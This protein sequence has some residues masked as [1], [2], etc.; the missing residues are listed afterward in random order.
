MVGSLGFL[1]WKAAKGELTVSDSTPSTRLDSG[2]RLRSPPKITQK[3]STWNTYIFYCTSPENQDAFLCQSRLP[4]FMEKPFRYVQNLSLPSGVVKCLWK[5]VWEIE[6]NNGIFLITFGGAR[7]IL[8]RLFGGGWKGLSAKYSP[9]LA[10]FP[11]PNIRVVFLPV[12]FPL[13]SSSE[14]S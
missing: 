5:V 9:C 12:S 8:L 1:A 10:E 11:L 7:Y 3:I 4:W 2:Q 6:V 14:C 13:K